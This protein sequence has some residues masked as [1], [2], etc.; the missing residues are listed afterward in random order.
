[1]KLLFFF[2]TRPEAI[3]L[4]PLV[5]ELRKYGELFDVK[6]CVSSMQME[7]LKQTLDFFEIGTDFDL[8]IGEQEQR[9]CDLLNKFIKGI[10]DVMRQCRPDYLIVQGDTTTSF[11]GALTAYYETVSVA[12]LDAGRRSLDRYTPFPEALNSRL[13]SQI[14][15]IHFTPSEEAKQN[16][17]K[18]SV[19]GNKIFVVGDTGV[20]T[21]YFCLDQ[22]RNKNP[23]EFPALQSVNFDRKIILVTER[24]ENRQ[25]SHYV[26]FDQILE[27]IARH[28]SVEVV[29]FAQNN[30]G[31]R[32]SV[33]KTLN[34]LTNVHMMEPPDFPSFVYLINRSCLV[35]TDSSRMQETASSLG[36]NVLAVGVNMD[37]TVGV[38]T[39]FTRTVGTDPDTIVEAASGLL[40]DQTAYARMA[41][42]VSY[43]GNGSACVKIRQI[44]SGIYEERI[45]NS[46]RRKLKSTASHIK[47]SR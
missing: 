16:L 36:K 32:R 33:S 41:R 13:T 25:E 2:G 30:T 47:N 44:L 27:G 22:I 9:H 42:A 31:I 1:M 12:H 8:N 37:E 10:S 38:E 5:K 3:K 34:T 45:S 4:S 26:N 18:E 19:P 15:D 39:N 7:T 23:G 28:D 46:S 29:Y 21:L 14:A 43:H 40:D 11:A 6:I 20:D 24:G 17:L 35:I